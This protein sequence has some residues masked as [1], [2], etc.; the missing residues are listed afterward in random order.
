MEFKIRT[1]NKGTCD[2]DLDLKRRHRAMFYLSLPTSSCPSQV[3]NNSEQ[4]KRVICN[5][6][7]EEDGWRKKARGVFWWG[8]YQDSAA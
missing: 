7:E 4:S 8:R 5:S 6:C 3:G 1:S 2:R